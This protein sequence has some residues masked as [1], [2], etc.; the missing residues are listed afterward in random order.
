MRKKKKR[1]GR[2]KKSKILLA[3]AMM[4][5]LLYTAESVYAF[6]ITYPTDMGTNTP[7][8]ENLTSEEY[9]VAA[10]MPVDTLA[11]KDTWYEFALGTNL[12]LGKD[13]SAFVELMKTT[14]GQVSTN[15]QVNASMS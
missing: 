12:Q 14:G 7:D 5:A 1:T 15:W 3:A 13:Q 2:A 11:G 9:Q 6:S 10:S 8:Q 4:A